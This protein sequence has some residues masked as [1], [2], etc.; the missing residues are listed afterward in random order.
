MSLLAADTTAAQARHTAEQIL[1][2]RRFRGAHLPDPLGSL[3]HE[4]GDLLKAIGKAITDFIDS[5][6]GGTG[7]GIGA[8]PLV[9]VATVV[10]IASI[11]LTRRA[12]RTRQAAFERDLDAAPVEARADARTLE[13]EADAAEGAGDFGRAVRLRFRAGLLRLDERGAVAVTASTTTREVARALR[14]P[15]FDRVAA[16]FDRVAYGHAEPAAA[17]ADLQRSGWQRVLTTTG[18]KR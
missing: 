17:D 5:L 10:L 4:V 12:I 3:L 14:S 8:L 15:E 1:A 11:V 18:G 9:V 16:G 2:E 7:H 13:R 6:L